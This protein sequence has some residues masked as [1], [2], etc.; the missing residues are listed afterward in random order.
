[1]PPT[2]YE[3]PKHG[4]K[5]IT[6]TSLISDIDVALKTLADQLDALIATDSQGLLAARPVSSP[7]QP[8]KTGRWYKSTD[9]GLLYRDHGQGYDQVVLGDDP[10]LSDARAVADGS[11]TN[12]KV[13]ATAAIAESKLALASDGAAAVATRRTLGTGAQQAAAGNDA[14][15]G[16]GGPPTG[17][18]G[19]S[20]SGTYPNP[21]LA[22]GAVSPIKTGTGAGGLAAGSF[23]A[24]RTSGATVPIGSTIIFDAEDFDVSGWYNAATGE[25]QPLVAGIYRVGAQLLYSSGLP[26]TDDWMSVQ[27]R[28]NGTLYKTVGQGSGESTLIALAYGGA[29]LV[30]MNG[31]TDKLTI[32]H[33]NNV[34]AAKAFAGATETYFYGELVGRT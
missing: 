24:G 31:T 17:S 6:G 23:S 2:Y 20:L 13:S 18:A 22:D 21:G 11:V 27:L 19:G 1:M 9:G 15:F 34:P 26:S 8:G 7:G 25:F 5:A 12:A 32:T 29:A 33:N 3:T 28:K 10:R 14:R 30:S 16:S 4:L